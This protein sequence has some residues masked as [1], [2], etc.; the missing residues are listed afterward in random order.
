[1][2]SE[3]MIYFSFSQIQPFGSMATN[4]I[5]QFGKLFFF[6]VEHYSRNSQ[7]FVRISAVRQQSL[8]FFTF[9]HYKSM[10]TKMP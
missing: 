10:A 9:P 7:M 4:Q 1:M 2:A 5:Q 3:E 6:L 8:P